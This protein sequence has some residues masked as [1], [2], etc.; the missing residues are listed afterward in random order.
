MDFDSFFSANVVNHKT[1]IIELLQLFKL[2]PA[3]VNTKIYILRESDNK[4]YFSLLN[5]IEECCVYCSEHDKLPFEELKYIPVSLIF[6]F[7]EDLKVKS[8]T[9]LISRSFYNLRVNHKNE[10]VFMEIT[11]DHSLYV[12]YS[13][14]KMLESLSHKYYFGIL[15]YYKEILRWDKLDIF[16]SVMTSFDKSSIMNI[17]DTLIEARKKDL[18][19]CTCSSGDRILTFSNSIKNLVKLYS[20]QEEVDEKRIST[21]RDNLNFCTL[22]HFLSSIDDVILIAQDLTKSVEI[23]C[24]SNRLKNAWL[25]YL[26]NKT[27]INVNSISSD[28]RVKLMP[29]NKSNT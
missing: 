28:Y 12:H 21:S 5:F 18:L 7:G 25:F 8:D 14:C 29:N 1:Q 26:I 4:L 6:K 3:L 19:R 9:F 24:K 2:K 20:S 11:D 23:H 16:Q 22:H 27:Y 13:I 15:S 10:D 17:R